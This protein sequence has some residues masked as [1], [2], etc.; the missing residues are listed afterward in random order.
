MGNFEGLF[1]RQALL[2]VPLVIC[3]PSR[4]HELMTEV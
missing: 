4:D 2:F 1:N 3:L